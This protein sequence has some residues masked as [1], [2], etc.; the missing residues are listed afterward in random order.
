MTNEGVHNPSDLKN[1]PLFLFFGWFRETRKTPYGYSYVRDSPDVHAL[2][3]WL[4]VEQ[5]IAVTDHSRIAS[6]MPW[7]ASHPHV[8]REDNNRVANSIY[9]APKPGAGTDRLILG[10]RDTQLP[11]SGV[12]SRFDPEIH[13]LTKKGRTRSHWILPSWFYR[14]GDPRLGMHTKLSC[15]TPTPNSEMVELQSVGRGQEFVF[16]STEHDEPSVF[17]WVERIVRAGQPSSMPVSGQE[18]IGA[19]NIG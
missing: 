8:V 1:R 3:G 13:V 16:E 15:W 4:Q 5:K 10:G 7:T 9:V 12:F 6:E 14:G 2:F 18:V 17:D 19:A 11:A